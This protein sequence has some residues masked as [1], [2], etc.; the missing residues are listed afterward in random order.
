[1]HVHVVAGERLVGAIREREERIKRFAL[2]VRGAAARVSGGRTN[3]R[4]FR[5]DDVVNDAPLPDFKLEL[6]TL[7]R[8]LEPHRPLKRSKKQVGGWRPGAVNEC[9]VYGG[10]LGHGGAGHGLHGDTSAC[11]TGF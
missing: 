1:M 4:R 3:V 2:R 11:C 5:T 7:V 8:L 6:S 9:T 10:R